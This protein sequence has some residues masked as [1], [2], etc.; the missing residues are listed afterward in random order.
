MLDAAGGMVETFPFGPAYTGGVRV[1]LGDI[2]GDGIADLI[3]GAGDSAAGHARVFDGA[4]GQLIRDFDAYPDDAFSGGLHVAAGDVNG[5]GRADIIVGSSAAQAVHVK[6][7]DGRTGAL[8]HSFSPY[9]PH[10]SGGVNVAA[11]DVNGDG[12]AD[13]VVAPASAGMPHVKVFSG[14][15]ASLLEEF[16][17]FDEPYLADGVDVAVADYDGDGKADISVGTGPSAAGGGGPHVRVFDG[18]TLTVI[19]NVFPYPGSTGGARVASGDI[20]GDGRADIITAAGA[21]ES[22]QISRFLAPDARPAGSELVFDASFTGGVRVALAT[23]NRVLF[24]DGFEVL[25]DAIE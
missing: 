22:P 2:T 9:E 18:A 21:G 11:G 4:S 15:D 24:R 6:V 25:E 5:D 10:Y 20:N 19:A 7:F 17:A 16:I 8:L 1:A 12:R 3:V 14:V 13:I 23:E